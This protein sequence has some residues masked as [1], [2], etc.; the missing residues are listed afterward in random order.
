MKRQYWDRIADRYE[1]EIF[2]VLKHDKAGL[3]VGK[4]DQYG[5][6]GKTASDIGCGIGSFLP[7]LSS[8]FHEVRAV[9]FSPKCIARAKAECSH[10]TNV[11]YMVADLAAP[12]VRLPKVDFALS[13]S[14]VITPSLLCRNRILDALCMHL[15]PSAHLVMVVPS[16]ESAFLVDFRLI[17]WNLRSGVAPRFA[18]RAHFRADEQTD[19]PRLR[20]GIVKI[21]GVGTKH[22]LEEE[23]VVLLENRGME[24]LE[25]QKIEYP[26]TTQFTAPPR[27]MK[28]PFPW[29]WLC[30]AEKVQ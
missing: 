3:I 18:A 11:T 1:A 9:D 20:E 14:S 2:N 17:E 22:Y 15:R 6:A 16:L 28:A 27:W 10:L 23:L 24:I 29:D 4:V 25:I 26:W 12:G 8:S 21:E 7:A 30:V 19:T 5:A 13:V